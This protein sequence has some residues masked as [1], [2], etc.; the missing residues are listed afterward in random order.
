[1][2]QP[3]ATFVMHT[4]QPLANGTGASILDVAYLKVA[5]R[6][7]L[8]FLPA[9]LRFDGIGTKGSANWPMKRNK[10]RRVLNRTPSKSREIESTKLIAVFD[11]YCDFVFNFVSPFAEIPN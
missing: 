8:R 4:L 5:A 9:A 6:Q 10:N 11:F 2:L 1:M 7:V 3:V